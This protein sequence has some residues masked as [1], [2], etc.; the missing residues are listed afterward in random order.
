MRR[1]KEDNI[2]VSRIVSGDEEAF[3]T[4]YD[5]YI[6]DIHRFI[7]FRVGSA[8]EAEDL[9]SEVFLRLW[10]YLSTHQKK[11]DNVRAL[12]Y[13]IARNAVIDHYRKNGREMV[14]LD[15]SHAETIE[16]TSIRIEE[17]AELKDEV[18]RLK[19]VITQLTPAEQELITLRY[20]DDLSVNE[21]AA[22]VEK[23]TG[24]VRVALHRAIKSL[25]QVLK[26]TS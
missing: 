19:E 24:A 9:A 15:E 20:V 21:I 18:S 13:R 16:D 22:I 25:K 10:Q 5:V 4:L 23:S 3:G 12:M 2:L 26:G 1:K 17:H 8:E 7:Y 14:A 6:N 11:V